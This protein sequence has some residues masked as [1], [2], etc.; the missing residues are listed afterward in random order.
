MKKMITLLVIFI[1]TACGKPIHIK[2]ESTKIVF[3]NSCINFDKSLSDNQSVY[4]KYNKE[5]VYYLFNLS[6]FIELNDTGDC[7]NYKAEIES[8]KTIGEA[9]T[10]RK[11]VSLHRFLMYATVNIYYQ[12]KIIEK[13]EY[14]SQSDADSHSF[15]ASGEKKLKQD[16][17]AIKVVLKDLIE[18]I[19]TGLSNPY[20]EN[21]EG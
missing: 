4:S 13:K 11:E 18:Q 10:V 12:N 17:I 7:F 1:L 9:V 15:L 3:H 21:Y 16:E 6:D 20:K 8:I 19:E 14:F 2:S 5:K